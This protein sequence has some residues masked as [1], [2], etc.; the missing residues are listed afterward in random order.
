[1]QKIGNDPEINALIEQT[2]KELA[3][4]STNGLQVMMYYGALIFREA[5]KH[6]TERGIIND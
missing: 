6:L 1:M 4:M 3:D 5:R 2:L